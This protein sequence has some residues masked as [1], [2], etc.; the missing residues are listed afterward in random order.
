MIYVHVTFN[1]KVVG[2]GGPVLACAWNDTSDMIA[3]SSHEGTVHVY[4]VRQY[5]HTLA[6]IGSTE[7]SAQ[8]RH[9]VYGYKSLCW[10]LLLTMAIQQFGLVIR[11]SPGKRKLSIR[12]FCV[13]AG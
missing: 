10:H 13:L 9:G 3:V 5:H 12:L 4:D 8:D 1:M 11:I 7:V 6:K 2:D